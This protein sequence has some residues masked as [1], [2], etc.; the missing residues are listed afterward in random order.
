VLF[1]QRL[2]KVIIV[3]EGALAALLVLLAGLGVI[4]VVIKMYELA[5][6]EGFLTPEGITRTIDTVLIVFIVIELFRIAVAYM[7]H[8]NVVG[9]V[10]EAGLVAV[11]RKLVIFEG[12]PESLTTALALALLILSVGITWFLLR[13]AGLCDP[14]AVE[15]VSGGEA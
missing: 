6:A 10:L 5:I 3:I 9:T 7:Q 4:D 8:R 13:R 11:V 14:G 1:I 2:D 15:R 12:G